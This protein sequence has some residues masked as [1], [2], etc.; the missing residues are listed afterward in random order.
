MYCFYICVIE[1]L[2]L[3]VV[4]FVKGKMLIRYCSNVVLIQEAD[5]FKCTLYLHTMLEMKTLPQNVGNYCL[6][7]YQCY[8]LRYYHKKASESHCLW[9]QTWITLY[10]RRVT[11][12]PFGCHHSIA[13]LGVNAVCGFKHSLGSLKYNHV[14]KG[15]RTCGGTP[16][17]QNTD[18]PFP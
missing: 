16:M 15:E 13:V 18:M 1:L 10:P 9:P 3:C 12:W 2:S 17:H 8:F 5:H 11:Q 6:L 7:F 14:H 4:S